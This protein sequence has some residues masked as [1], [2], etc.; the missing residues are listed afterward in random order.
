MTCGLSKCWINYSTT[1]RDFTPVGG[2]VTVCI[3]DHINAVSVWVENTGSP[4][5]VHNRVDAFQMFSGTRNDSTGSHLGLGLYVVRL[6]AE[7]MGAQVSIGNTERGVRVEV[8]GLDVPKESALVG[9]V[10]RLQCIKVTRLEIDRVYIHISVIL[11]NWRIHAHKLYQYT[12]EPDLA[13]SEGRLYPLM[14][15]AVTAEPDVIL[16]PECALCLSSNQAISRAQALTI[17]APEVHRLRHYAAHHAVTLIVGS[18]IMAT[19][20]GVKGTLVIN[21]QGVI[22]ATYDKIHLFDV[23][24]TSGESYRAYFSTRVQVPS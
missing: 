18:L 12:A 16:L 20:Q 3:R 4:L 23:D 13:I 2:L 22:Q 19:D 17:D 10:I 1:P 15:E 5:Q 14:D 8:T 21:P 9:D 6:I 7:S 24:L 11:S